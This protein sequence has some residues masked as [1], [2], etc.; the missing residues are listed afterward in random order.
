[1]FPLSR[2]GKTQMPTHALAISVSI[3]A[4]H[5]ISLTEMEEGNYLNIGGRKKRGRQRIKQRTSSRNGRSARESRDLWSFDFS[6]A[7]EMNE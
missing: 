1:M 2:S 5:G 7:I 4:G 3:E 6:P